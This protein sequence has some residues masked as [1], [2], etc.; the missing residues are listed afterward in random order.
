MK[1]DIV[2]QKFLNYEGITDLC[3]QVNEIR[4]SM[5]RICPEY[6]SGVFLLA[7]MFYAGVSF[8]SS[9][10]HSRSFPTDPAGRDRAGRL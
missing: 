6:A 9:R 10:E 4:K 1:S 5:E 8:A 2:V 7:C 3:K